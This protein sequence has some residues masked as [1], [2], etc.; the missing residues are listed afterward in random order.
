[1]NKNESEI[2]GERTL[3]IIKEKYSELMIRINEDQKDL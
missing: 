2:I 1:M 3:K